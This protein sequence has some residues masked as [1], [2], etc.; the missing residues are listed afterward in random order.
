[1]SNNA[2]GRPSHAGHVTARPKA[3][4]VFLVDLRMEPGEP[5][6]GTVVCALDFVG[7]TAGREL[8]HPEM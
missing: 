1:M 7:E 5:P 4:Q 8:V 2:S 3:G 6:E